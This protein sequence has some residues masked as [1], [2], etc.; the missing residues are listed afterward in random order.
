MKADDFPMFKKALVSY[1][2]VNGLTQEQFA[3]QLDITVSALQKWEAGVNLPDF[4]MV[5]KLF[6]Q[7]GEHGWWL[8][9]AMGLREEDVADICRG[10]TKRKTFPQSSRSQGR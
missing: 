10:F 4:G 3:R 9:G 8:L 7:F 6:M 1:R 2:D 5:G